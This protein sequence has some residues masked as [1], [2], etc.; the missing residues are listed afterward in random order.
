MILNF[1]IGA[2]SEHY[3]KEII[4]IQMSIMTDGATPNTWIHDTQ[5]PGGIFNIPSYSQDVGI[6]HEMAK[7]LRQLKDMISSVSRGIQPKS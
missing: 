6:G 3:T 1:E 4:L 5:D 2:C 7:K